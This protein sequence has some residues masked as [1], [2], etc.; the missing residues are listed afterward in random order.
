[1]WMKPLFMMVGI[2]H[3][4]SGE[5]KW[6]SIAGFLRMLRLAPLAR[7]L[8]LVRVF[9]E[10]DLSWTEG[11]KLQGFIMGLIA[12]NSVI[13]GF[14]SDLL[15]SP[16]WFGVEQTLLIIFTFEVLV[17]LKR[18]GCYFFVHPRD[19]VRNWLDFIIVSGGVVDM[20][21]MPAIGIVR[22]LMGMGP[23][24]KGG[25]GQ[26]VTILRM[27]RLL[28]ILRLVRLVNAVDRLAHAEPTSQ[29]P[30]ERLGHAEP[31]SQHDVDLLMRVMEH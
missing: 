28:R 22:D 25:L 23:M 12:A 18:W 19:V 21:M 9:L 4:S 27:M 7:L 3:K 13:M 11:P 6:P 1:M 14:E 8:K 17:R 16:I 2:M 30:A 15:T 26:V 20:W 10:S 5:V 29:R 31:T 24:P